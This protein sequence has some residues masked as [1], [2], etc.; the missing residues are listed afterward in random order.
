MNADIDRASEERVKVIKGGVP[1]ERTFDV[2]NNG[3]LP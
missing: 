3:Q 2:W 1:M